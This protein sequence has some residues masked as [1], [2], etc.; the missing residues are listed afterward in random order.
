MKINYPTRIVLS[1]VNIL[2]YGYGV[3]YSLED[4]LGSEPHIIVVAC[5][6]IVGLFCALLMIYP[7]D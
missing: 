1:V 3:L 6:M 5:F 7:K 4:L 2:F